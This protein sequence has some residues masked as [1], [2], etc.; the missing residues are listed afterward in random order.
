[1]TYQSLSLLFP[2]ERFFT[3]AFIDKI[4]LYRLQR[5]ENVIRILAR[6]E[7]LVLMDMTNSRVFVPT[8]GRGRH[9]QT[10]S[11][12]AKFSNNNHENLVIIYLEK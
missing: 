2:V 3:L 6:M 12:E 7:P 8:D 11:I 10:V 4:F 9:V 5:P 1:M